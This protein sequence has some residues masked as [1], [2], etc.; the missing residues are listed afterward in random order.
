MLLAVKLSRQVGAV[1][2]RDNEILATGANDCPK[3]GGGLYWPEY[4]EKTHQITDVK[5]GRDYM[6][7][8]D[9][10]KAQQ[11]KIVDDVLERL[12]E[13]VDKN[14]VRKAMEDSQIG[15]ITEY[16]RMVHAEME[17]LLSAREVM[18]ARVTQLSCAIRNVPVSDH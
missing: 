7:E 9:A 11:R 5:D 12:D 3:F 10:N 13:G 2:A 1:V 14:V 16:G 4:D 6:R 8:E 18:Q 15:D 17:A